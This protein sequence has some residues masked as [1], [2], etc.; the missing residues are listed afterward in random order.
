MLL[1]YEN[2]SK[3]CSNIVIFTWVAVHRTHCRIAGYE[4]DGIEAS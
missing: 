4:T 3:K 1:A 2:S